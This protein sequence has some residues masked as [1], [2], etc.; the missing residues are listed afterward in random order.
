M[1][2]VAGFTLGGMRRKLF[3]FRRGVLTLITKVWPFMYPE[4]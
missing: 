2:I 4:G 1:T 3:H